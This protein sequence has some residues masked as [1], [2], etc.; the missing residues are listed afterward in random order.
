VSYARL[1]AKAKEV[2][3]DADARIAE[4]YSVAAQVYQESPI[5]L[6]LRSME[7]LR[8]VVESGKASTIIIPSDAFGHVMATATQQPLA[9]A[10]M[11]AVHPDL[12]GVT[13]Q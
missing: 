9:T 1:S 10:A 8:Q 2:Q 7:L 12:R 6:Q 3:A 4:R 5:S 11:R 13:I